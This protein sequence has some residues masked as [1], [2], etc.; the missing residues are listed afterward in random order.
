MKEK[1]KKDEDYFKENIDTDRLEE[2]QA[3]N[4]PNN[5][6]AETIRD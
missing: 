5:P 4:S 6:I 1:I 3:K 2:R